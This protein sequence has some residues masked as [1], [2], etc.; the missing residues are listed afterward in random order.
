MKKL[1]YSC[2]GCLIHVLS[3][4]QDP[5]AVDN[6]PPEMETVSVYSTS[7]S[8]YDLEAIATPLPILKRLSDNCTDSSDIELALRV[9]GTGVG[10]PDGQTTLSF[11][12]DYQNVHV[13]I[14][15]WARDAAGN[16]AVTHELIYISEPGSLPG[17]GNPCGGWA[18]P[19]L[20]SICAQTETGNLIHGYGATIGFTFDPKDTITYIYS[21]QTIDK[22]RNFPAF[23]QG[24][25][26]LYKDKFPLNGV[27]TLDLVQ[28]NKHILGTEKL[29]SPYKIIAADANRSG[30]TSTFD[31]LELRKL[32]LG[33]YEKLPNN[34]SWRFLPEDYIFQDST[35][36]FPGMPVDTFYHYFGASAGVAF[37]GWYVG[38]KVGDVNGSADPVA[39]TGKNEY[40]SVT[41][42]YTLN[43]ELLPEDEIE[44]PLW[45]ADVGGLNGLQISFGTD[46]L[47]ARITGVRSDVL[48]GFSGENYHLTA[49][50]RLRLVWFD[51]MTTDLSNDE[52]VLFLK[53]RTLENARLSEVL[54]LDVNKLTAQLVFP[55]QVTTGI[56]LNFIQENSVASDCFVSPNPFTDQFICQFQTLE[57]GP[58]CWSLF[59]A[60]GC[61]VM[62]ETR[63]FLAGK[64]TWLFTGMSDLPAG[65]YFY[66]LQT[67][68]NIFTGS[69]SR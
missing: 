51:V 58:A 14:E 63:N 41:N 49:E 11:N 16:T 34:T 26:A 32:L 42:L 15:I 27:S 9:T 1:L 55:D 37:N 61:R 29:D 36:P 23:G 31:L 59:H 21:D 2:L 52:P 13:D 67:G 47:K 30:T 62:D 20:A 56:I 28:I 12:C 4:A 39:F 19:S 66:R 57:P 43:R 18:D 65:I 5:C 8:P 35:N 53:I 10:F 25:V 24:F 50:G 33:I 48:P 45:L 7:I 69:L 64:Q 17:S 3:V 46:T 68:G 54:F 44:I 38:I 22:C 6:I 40:R 60:S